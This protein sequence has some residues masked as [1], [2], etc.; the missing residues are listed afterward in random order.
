MRGLARGAAL[1]VCIVLSGCAQQVPDNMLSWTAETMQY[2]ELSRRVY[3]TSKEEHALRAVGGVLQDLGYQITEGDHTLG[4]LTAAKSGEGA[5]L[6]A[7]VLVALFGGDTRAL[8]RERHV[9]VSVVTHIDRARRLHVRAT[10][11]AIGID[12]YGNMAMAEKLD[13]P[14]LY[15]GFFSKLDKALF[16]EGQHE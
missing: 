10:F 14:E 13:E 9:R 4:F 11:Q 15:Q 1:C 3:E 5:G 12:G 2:R 16:L 8:L 7:H 6:G